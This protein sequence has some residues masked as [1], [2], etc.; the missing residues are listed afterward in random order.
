MRAERLLMPV[1]RSLIS[2]RR[3][4]CCGPE[5]FR[6]TVDG[7]NRSDDFTAATTSSTPPGFSPEHPSPAKPFSGSIADAARVAISGHRR[8]A[9][10]KFY[11][12]PKNEK[13]RAA[14]TF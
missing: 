1:W 9:R 4:R 2:E 3:R 14:V 5:D 11:Q 8:D 10:Q 6:L 13:H 7:R 12:L